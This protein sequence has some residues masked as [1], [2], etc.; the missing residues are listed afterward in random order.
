MMKVLTLLLFCLVAISDAHAA[1]LAI[2][3]E[4]S[5]A[6][7]YK[8]L[9]LLLESVKDAES[10]L[11]YKTAIEKEIQRLRQNQPS[12]AEYFNSLSNADKKLFIKR[13]QK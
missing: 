5:Y 1:S 6:Q 3:S 10:A 7:E 8:P 9:R 12:G 13:F 11:A 2:K 4:H